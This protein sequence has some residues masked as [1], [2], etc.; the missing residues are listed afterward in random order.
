MPYLKHKLDLYF[1]ENFPREIVT[2]FQRVK[3][4]RRRCRIHSVHDYG[5]ENK[6]DAFQYAF[7]KSKGYTLVTLD[8]DFWNDTKYPFD[9]MPGVI[10]V[11]AGR[12][13]PIKIQ[14]CLEML[15]AFLS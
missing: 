9:G 14:D 1:D 6:D 13:E 15:L 3:S 2:S 8:E 10:Q 11:I 4:W 7:C 5:N 12:N